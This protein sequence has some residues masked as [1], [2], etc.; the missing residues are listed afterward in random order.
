MGGEN[1]GEP[2]IDY[3]KMGHSI[4]AY[5][6][7]KEVEVVKGGTTIARTKDAILLHETGHNPVYYFP[8]KDVRKGCLEAT[9]TR[10][11]C[12]Y[13]GVANY[14]NIRVGEVISI[15]SVW[16]YAD[17]KEEFRAIREYVAFYP[18][19]IDQINVG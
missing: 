5:M 7:G 6:V 13:K 10:T 17:S 14:Y 19:T 1:L 8:L 4:R 12:P 18:N 3:E 15:D 9:G 11:T 2:I 16:Q